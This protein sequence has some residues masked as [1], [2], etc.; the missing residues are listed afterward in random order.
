MKQNLFIDCDGI[1]LFCCYSQ[2]EGDFNN[3]TGVLLVQPF[4]EERILM[5][6]SLFNLDDN[7]SKS[8]YPVCRFD[9]HGQG[10][11]EGDFSDT[12]LHLWKKNLAVAITEFKNKY[13]LDEVILCGFRIGATI[14][15]LV[16][17]E[18]NYIKRLILIDPVINGKNYIEGV[19][20]TNLTYQMVTYGEILETRDVLIEKLLSGENVNIDGYLLNGDFYRQLCDIDLMNFNVTCQN[21][22]LLNYSR[23]NKITKEQSRYIDYLGKQNIQIKSSAVADPASWKASELYNMQLNNTF[24][25]IKCWAL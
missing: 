19:L 13:S 6:R 8:G 4:A 3:H 10:D 20:R 15:V 22:L 24:D 1:K 14:S 9:F 5:Q 21:I 17:N 16:A 23:T 18:I 11:S 12:N 2:P 25:Q 7:I